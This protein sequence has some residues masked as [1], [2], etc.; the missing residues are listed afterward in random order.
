MFTS[1]PVIGLT[2]G[3]PAGIG[4]E[5]ILKSLRDCKLNFDPLLIGHT[6]IFQLY[7]GLCG[8]DW[9]FREVSS[10]SEIS[11]I[12]NSRTLPVYSLT[13]KR[14]IKFQ[15]GKPNTDGAAL[16]MEAVATAVSL[17]KKKEIHAIVTAPIYKKGIQQA[18]YIFNGH[19]DYIA[20][21]TGTDDYA[22]MLTGEGLSVVLVTIHI[23]FRQI[24][25]QLT[26]ESVV[27]TLRITH[28]GFR[29]FG[30]SS[31][32]IALCGLN[33]HAGEEGML[34]DEEITILQPAVAQ[35]RAEN[36]NVTGIFP[37]DTVFWDTVHGAA[38]VVVALYHDQG[39]IP[40]K[41]LAFDKGVN[42][43]LGLP[44]VR[45]SPDHGTAFG[46][47]GKNQANPA[48]FTEAI[49][50]ALKMCGGTP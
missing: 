31:P 7:N 15:P 33:P 17:A 1:R 12:S 11:A 35:A 18:G 36:I 14:E 27:R 47:A 26:V 44:I 13:P 34:G 24:R 43:T 40:L 39:L 6:E 30:L 32:R 48:S 37:P 46:I 8:L 23:P 10:I 25:D 16:A 41:L 21:L 20:H 5:V 50:L 19:T 49:K 2:I 45:T 9:S 42:C 28:N 3:D 38:D 29:Q 22:M 4:P